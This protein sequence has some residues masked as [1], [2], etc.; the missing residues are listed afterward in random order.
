M[1]ILK[2]IS[3]IIFLSLFFAVSV[4]GQSIQRIDGTFISGDSLK[5]E[6]Q[7]LMK[8]ANVSGLGISVFNKNKPVFSVAFGLSNVP[9]KDSLKTSSV[10]YGASFSKAVFAYIVM[11]L[12][13]EKII[14]LDKPLGEYLS[15]PLVEYK[16]SNPRKGYQDLA[17]DERYKKITGRMCLDHTTGFPNWRW[18]ETDNKLKIKFDPGTRY[19][20]SGEGI[21]LLQFVIEQIVG[22]DYETIARERVFEPFGMTNSS[23]IWQERF[24]DNLCLGHNSKGEPYNFSKR[25]EASAGGSLCTTLDDYTKFFTAVMQQK[26][27]TKASF[28]EMIKPQVI[29]KSKQQFGPN[30]LLDNDENNNIHL[31]Y[32]LGF[33]VMKTPNG[34]AFFKEG[35]DDGWGHYS[36]GFPDK[37]IAVII[38]TNNDNGESIFKELLSTSIGDQYTPWYWENYIPYNQKN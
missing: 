35:H 3:S 2:Y 33:G 27:L 10:L 28:D 14:D 18:F 23:Y 34:R 11:Q 21:Y 19:S 15:R 37:G 25:K 4:F 26:G 16:F 36:I 1:S 22:K 24:K 6:I 7:R 20:Y 8:E 9:Q 12:V 31:A 30:A 32:G 17:N 38:M 13:Q 5:N 29:I